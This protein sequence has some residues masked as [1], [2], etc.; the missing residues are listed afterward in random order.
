[1]PSVEITRNARQVLRLD[2][3]AMDHAS[4][5]LR[6]EGTTLSSV[7]FSGLASGQSMPQRILATDQDYGASLDGITVSGTL[8]ALPDGEEAQVAI[9]VTGYEWI[10]VDAAGQSTGVLHVRAE[11]H[12]LTVAPSDV[13]ADPFGARRVMYLPQIAAGTLKTDIVPSTSLAY[14]W[15]FKIPKGA[16]LE[17]IGFHVVASPTTEATGR[18]G[19]YDRHGNKVTEVEPI[20]DAAHRDD[21]LNITTV[22][23]DGLEEFIVVCHFEAPDS[24]ALR[25]SADN[26]GTVLPGWG[27]LRGGQVRETTPFGR[28]PMVVA[29]SSGAFPATLSATD[30]GAEFAIQSGSAANQYW[31]VAIVRPRHHVSDIALQLLSPDSLDRLT[32]APNVG[33]ATSAFTRAT[34]AMVFDG[35]TDLW[36]EVQANVPRFHGCRIGTDGNSYLT[37]ASGNLLHPRKQLSVPGHLDQRVVNTTIHA[38]YDRAARSTAYAVGARVIPDGLRPYNDGAGGDPYDQGSYY[39]ECITAGTSHASNRIND[40]W[41]LTSVTLGSTTITDGTVTWVVKGKYCRHGTPGVMNEMASANTCS[42]PR[43]FT[44]NWTNTNTVVIESATGIDGTTQSIRLTDND[45]AN[46]SRMSLALTAPNA[47]ENWAVAYWVRKEQA[48]T[49]FPNFRLDTD[50]AT[51]VLERP[52]FD[53]ETGAIGYDTGENDGYSYVEDWG[54]WW[55][56]VLGVTLPADGTLVTLSVYPGRA[57]T[58]DGAGVASG[59]GSVTVDWVQLEEGFWPTSPIPVGVTRARESIS[60]TNWHAGI[61]RGRTLSRLTMTSL[62]A[63]QHSVSNPILCNSAGDTAIPIYIEGKTPDAVLAN[64]SKIFVFDGGT[65]GNQL[66]QNILNLAGGCGLGIAHTPN[67]TTTGAKLNG[68]HQAT[69]VAALVTDDDRGGQS[70]Q[71]SGWGGRISGLGGS[72]DADRNGLGY[73]W[74]TLQGSTLRVGS[75]SSSNRHINGIVGDVV[76]YNDAMLDPELIDEQLDAL[77]AYDTTA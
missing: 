50:G 21:C 17:A 46:Q 76:L 55:R 48:G 58:I 57:A 66:L 16:V 71:P 2:C 29:W 43:D 54:H 34:T 73:L 60:Y 49:H 13:P 61:D 30:W 24:I 75:N 27:A 8:P 4:V 40:V 53:P 39:L 31:P 37:D 7:I 9:D 74:A 32:L 5:V 18:I 23:L 38:N 68:Q 65:S 20:I 14:A 64:L 42:S 70:A 10:S 28:H 33:D 15:P 51:P 3:R 1:M 77:G 41:S 72:G 69:A 63:G 19:I 44:S 67:G 11:E 62:G 12:D 25:G 52:N 36:A 59:V 26:E 56:L 22:N 47:N 45:A 35:A 6:A